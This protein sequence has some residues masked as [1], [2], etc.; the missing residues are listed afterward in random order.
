MAHPAAFP[1]SAT[2]PKTETLAVFLTRRSDTPNSAQHDVDFTN[3]FVVIYEGIRKV[4][5]S[6][7]N[8]IGNPMARSASSQP[9]EVELQILRVLWEHGECTVRQVH[10]A[11]LKHRATG[12]STTLKMMQVMLEKGLL[13]RDESVRP[14]TY[15]ATDPESKTQLEMLDDLAQRVFHGSAMR[16]VMRMVSSGRLSAEELDEIKRLTESSEGDMEQ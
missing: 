3:S 15:R 13:V 8:R 12:L 5:M 9:T 14:Q 1:F 11:L 4:A 10:E 2:P 16:L 7:K 6:G